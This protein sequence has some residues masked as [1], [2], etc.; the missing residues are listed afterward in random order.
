M[1]PGVTRSMF[2]IFRKNRQPEP[3]LPKVDPRDLL[4]GDAPMSAWPGYVSNAQRQPWTSFVKALEHVSAG[5]A[6]AAIYVLHQILK[7]PNL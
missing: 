6:I 3:P 7:M 1:I 5:N 2:E 4:F